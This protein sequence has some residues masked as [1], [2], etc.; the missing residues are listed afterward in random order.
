[1]NVAGNALSTGLFAAGLLLV[2]SSAQATTLYN[3]SVNPDLSNNQ[4]APTPLTLSLGTNSIIGSVGTGDLQDWVALT[5]PAG[6]KLMSL[7]LASYQST[8][9]QGFMGVQAGSSFVGNPFTAGPYLGYVHFGTGATNNGPPTNLVGADL[10]PLMGNTTI[11]AGSHGFTPPLGSDTYT[12]LIQQ[13]GSPTA[14]RF[15][16]NVAAVPEPATWGLLAL[17]GALFAIARAT[18]KSHWR[19]IPKS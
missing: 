4:A 3:E 17:G 9:A 7:V 16:F 6:D 18:S 2:A 15:D 19:C 8:D 12:F 10:L 5:V 14:Y 11:A 1:M 13:L